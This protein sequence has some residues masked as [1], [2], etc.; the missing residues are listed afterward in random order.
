MSCKMRYVSICGLLYATT[1]TSIHL[2]RRRRKSNSLSFD[3]P[4]A[5]HHSGK[6][7]DQESKQIIHKWISWIKIKDH[8][9]KGDLHGLRRAGKREKDGKLMVSRLFTLITVHS[10]MCEIRRSISIRIVAL[11]FLGGNSMWALDR[12][13]KKLSR[14][15]SAINYVLCRMCWFSFDSFGKWNA[16]FGAIATLKVAMWAICNRILSR[17]SSSPRFYQCVTANETSTWIYFISKL[18]REIKENF[19]FELSYRAA[20]HL[21]FVHL[22]STQCAHRRSAHSHRLLSCLLSSFHFKLNDLTVYW[23]SS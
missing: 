19:Q 10:C 14:A 12:Q 17:R 4:A 6:R 8:V 2:A 18:R 16:F 11:K 15:V 23:L 5:Q 3:V 13:K 1:V 9:W 7:Y 21:K 20:I 22:Q